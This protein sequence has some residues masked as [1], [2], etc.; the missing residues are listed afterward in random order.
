MAFNMSVT[1]LYSKA[2]LQESPEVA[3][4]LARDVLSLAWWGSVVA[5]L[6]YMA[7][8][9]PIVAALAPGFSEEGRRLA[10]T[11]TRTLSVC[12]VL[13]NLHATFDSLLNA[14]HHYLLP[15]VSML[16]IPSAT[17]AGIVL[18]GARWGM[19]GV[20]ASVLAGAALQLL[21]VLPAVKQV[22]R[23]RTHS[24]SPSPSH[25]GVVLRQFGYSV[26]IAGTPQANAIIDRLFG[27]MLGEG[28]VAALSFGSVV[29]AA[30]PGLV[31]LPVYKVLFPELQR[32]IVAG[33]QARLKRLISSNFLMVAL[34][35]FPIAG[36]LLAFATPVTKL[37]FG[38]GAFGPEAVAETARVIYF[39]GLGLF[40]MTA[41]I[42]VMYYFFL[43]GQLRFLVAVSFASVALNC[44]L[45][46]CLIRWMGLAGIA[47]TSTL[48][49]A[50][51]L[52][53]IVAVLRRRLGPLG[54]PSLILPLLKLAVASAGSVGLVYGLNQQLAPHVSGMGRVGDFVL[55]GAALASGLA[56][57][58]LLNLL[59]RN[60]IFLQ[61][62]RK[63]RTEPQLA[64]VGG[65]APQLAKS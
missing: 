26:L 11:L 1:P 46:Y 3:D 56:S 51:R 58:L 23:P 41:G 42:L 17:I 5:A 49:V 31:V 28:A 6:V 53:F 19:P 32:M 27:S 12:I 2:R 37:V 20:A 40:P 30:F 15:A 48:V 47:L 44:V 36:G 55:G 62:L 18:L 57:Y 8:A 64:T 22:W 52:V 60:T 50:I 38:Y 4:R 29:I 9:E 10:V 61:I 34:T 35:T 13:L 59:L 24:V 25:F 63:N 39:L 14:V 54:F 43:S 45:D 21:T 65:P 16:W 7:L 33:D